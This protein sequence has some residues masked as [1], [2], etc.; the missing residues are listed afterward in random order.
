M[1]NFNKTESKLE[2]SQS[3]FSIHQVSLYSTNLWKRGNS[4]KCFQIKIF[5]FELC[6]KT[7]KNS[8]LIKCFS[9]LSAIRQTFANEMQLLLQFKVI[10]HRRENNFY[11]SFLP[12]AALK[13]M[14]S[15]KL[16]SFANFNNTLGSEASE[17][18]LL[19]LF[20]IF[21]QLKSS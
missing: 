4:P 17:R 21:E 16:L 2:T 14:K 20:P 1:E 3:F 13:W 12:L 8:I 5:F 10:I 9:M 18:I 6:A 15:Q 11:A 19:K 7:G